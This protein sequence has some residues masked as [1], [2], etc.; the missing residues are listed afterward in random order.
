MSAPLTP[1]QVS[2]ELRRLR[3]DR[4]NRYLQDDVKWVRWVSIADGRRCSLCASMHDRI[5]AMNDPEWPKLL[6]LHAGC[7]CRFILLLDREVQRLGL[8]L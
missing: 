3:R 2:R 6:Q 5:I 8:T 1:A 7:R 4:Y